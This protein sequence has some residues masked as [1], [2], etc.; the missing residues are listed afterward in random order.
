METKGFF[1]SLFDF[2]FRALVT[3][4]IVPI[5]YVLS[6]I[7]VVIWTLVFIIFGFQISVGTGIVALVLAPFV[8]AI[9]MIYVRVVLE[10]I[11]VLFRIHDDVREINVRGGGGVPAAQPGP[12]PEAATLGP[13]PAPAITPVPAQASRPVDDTPATSFCTSCGAALAQGASFCTKC[14][15]PAGGPVGA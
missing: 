6:T 15:Q 13:N 9:A 12:A 1:A 2:S 3:S 14:G 7:I 4:K 11:I 8:F 10:L 5:L